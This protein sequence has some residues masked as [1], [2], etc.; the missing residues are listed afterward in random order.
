VPSRFFLKSPNV[1][2]TVA[3]KHMI[4]RITTL[5]L[6]ALTVAP[7]TDV[8]GQSENGNVPH[9][10]AQPAHG[11]GGADYAHREMKSEVFG[12]GD[13][14]YWIFEPTAPVPSSAPLVVFLHGWAAMGPN[15]YGAWIEHLVRRGNIVIYPRYQATVTT[16][17]DVFT[18]NTIGAVK[19]ALAKLASGVHVKPDLTRVAIVGHSMGASIAANLAALAKE[20]KLPA[21]KALM[22]IEP[23]YYPKELPVFHMPRADLS[24][25]P[26]STLLL[27]VVGENDARAGTLTAERI[28]REATAIPAANKNFVTLRSDRHGKPPLVAGHFAPAA[29]KQ[30]VTATRPGGDDLWLP[31]ATVR[32]DALDF[33]GTWKLFDGL[34]DAA[35][36]GRNREYALGDTP[37]QRYMGAWSDGTPV[38]ELVNRRP[39]A[40]TASGD[41]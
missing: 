9:P 2:S 28:F 12:E 18:P 3:V 19:A 36:F 38:K 29:F 20:E 1:K 13:D 26:A 5:L 23:A 14:E 30:I 10:P 34:T 16:S 24:K 39:D 32:A 40:A 7:A 25:I 35:F 15:G 27:L 33:F 8:P 22:S 31:P 11:P 17:M 37:E 4:T 41:K 6:A 21:P